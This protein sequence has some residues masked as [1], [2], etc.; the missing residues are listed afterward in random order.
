VGHF[1]EKEFEQD[2]AHRSEQPASVNAG[3]RRS[4]ASD[5]RTHGGKR[6]TKKE[7]KTK[8]KRERKG[9][10]RGCIVKF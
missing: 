10:E 9:K 3:R 8:G 5:Q 6:G 2:A 4:K 7:A 1:G